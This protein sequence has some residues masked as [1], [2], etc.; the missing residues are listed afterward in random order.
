M[1]ERSRLATQVPSRPAGDLGDQDLIARSA[2]CRSWELTLIAKSKQSPAMLDLHL[3]LRPALPLL[4]SPGQDL[5]I[6][7][8]QDYERAIRR[9]YT[10]RN[11]NAER[12]SVGI[13]V[14]LHGSGV[15]TWWAENL[16]EGDSVTAVGPRGKIGINRNALGHI[17]VGDETAV[18]AMASMAGSLVPGS[19]VVIGVVQ[20]PELWWPYPTSLQ[21]NWLKHSAHWSKTVSELVRGF[22]L[23]RSLSY[24]QVHAYLAG[25]A[26]EMLWWRDLLVELGLSAQQISAKAYWGGSKA[27]AT[28]GEPI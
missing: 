11:Y 9:R 15:G 24:L 8:L 5:T 3:S 2:F 20:E 4:F 23:S 28:H 6:T 27:N 13:Q 18:P 14:F 17:F 26:S 16:R 25:E 12:H 22:I 21:W 7:V 19:G 10:V 1:D